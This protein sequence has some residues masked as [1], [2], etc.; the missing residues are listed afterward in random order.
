MFCIPIDTS[1]KPFTTWFSYILYLFADWYIVETFITC[2]EELRYP[3]VENIACIID[4]YKTLVFWKDISIV[5]C[6]SW[7]YVLFQITN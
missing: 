3:G 4:D 7:I 1:M 6:D 5:S 2:N